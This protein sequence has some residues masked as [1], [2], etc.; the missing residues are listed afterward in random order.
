M[1]TATHLYHGQQLRWQPLWWQLV[2][3]KQRCSVS[4]KLCCAVHVICS[5]H[6]SPHTPAL[7]LTVWAQANNTH[8]RFIIPSQLQSSSSSADTISH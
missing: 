8:E 7:P 3:V 1:L 4:D 5:A 2:P 6:S